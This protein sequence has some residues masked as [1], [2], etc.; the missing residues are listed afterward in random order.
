MGCNAE[1]DDCEDE[2]EGCDAELEDWEVDVAIEVGD[3]LGAEGRP[4][5]GERTAAPL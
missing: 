2:F 4:S 1:L 5:L 3:E